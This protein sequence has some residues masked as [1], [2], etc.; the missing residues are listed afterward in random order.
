MNNDEFPM[1]LWCRTKHEMVDGC[2]SKF[3]KGVQDKQRR[4]L[5]G[6]KLP[7]SNERVY[8]FQ[9]GFSHYITLSGSRKDCVIM[10]IYVRLGCYRLWE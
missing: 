9:L 5:C 1:E 3:L 10:F 8:G 6:K 4:F 7:K 2:W